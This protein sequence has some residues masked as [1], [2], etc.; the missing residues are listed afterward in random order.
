MRNR[1][2]EW[3][4][5]L[6]MK[7][8]CL[9]QRLVIHTDQIQN[10][11]FTAHSMEENHGKKFYTKMKIQVLSRLRSILKTQISYMQ[12]CGR[13]ARV[14]GRMARGTVPKAAYSNRLMEAPPG[15]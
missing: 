7:T 2:A 5:M 6:R 9:L 11:E 1:S 3:Q 8:G 10:A 12:T 14:P 4:L 13:V 15:K